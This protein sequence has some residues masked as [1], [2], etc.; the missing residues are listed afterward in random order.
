[1]TTGAKVESYIPTPDASSTIPEKNYHHLYNKHFKEPSTLIRFSSTVEDIIGCPYV[2]DEE[3][4]AF[5]KEHNKAA[6]A[7]PISEDNFEQMMW[8]Y[9]T[10]ANQHWPHLDLVLTFGAGGGHCVRCWS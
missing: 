7:D 1:M 6:S 10:T 5:L 8:L 3:D 2:M 9:E 4:E